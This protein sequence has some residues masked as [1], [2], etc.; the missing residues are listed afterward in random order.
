MIP[1]GDLA[2][3]VCSKLLGS[4]PASRLPN[5]GTDPKIPAPWYCD[6]SLAR[7]CNL[8]VVSKN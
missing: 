6:K 4:S 5:G 7:D 3:W 2:P 8:N 1:I